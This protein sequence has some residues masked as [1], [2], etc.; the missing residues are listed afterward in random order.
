M[1][2]RVSVGAVVAVFFLACSGS[3]SSPGELKLV[4]TVPGAYNILA[5]AGH[6]DVVAALDYGTLRN[7]SEA[8]LLLGKRDPAHPT[9]LVDLGK[10]PL[11][12]NIS[13]LSDLSVTADWV[14]VACGGVV[15]AVSLTTPA[16]QLVAQFT[17]ASLQA[18]ASGRWLL[19]VDGDGRTV[20]VRDLGAPG[21]GFPQVGS[22]FDAGATVTAVAA[23]PGGFLAFTTA[24]YGYVAMAQNVPAYTFVSSPDVKG[25]TR[26]HLYGTKLYVGGPS[27]FMGKIRV[28]R[29]DVAT[30]SSATLEAFVD[31]D[32]AFV[33][34]AYDPAGS[35]VAFAQV[36]ADMGL[37]RLFLV[38]DTGGALA[39]PDTSYEI[40]GV[41]RGTTSLPLSH[42]K[43]GMLYVP[44]HSNVYVS[45]ASD[46]ALFALP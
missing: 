39:P 5:V 3:G 46:I 31:I 20:H 15:S 18:I 33:D 27:V 16:P 6:D 12:A 2:T 32:G 25:F 45:T 37:H 29:I 30:P 23:V 44:Y 34:F 11:G 28:G 4:R 19:H 38:R 8:L 22:P 42:A 14:T 17:T 36:S 1:A 43:S 40:R 24:G 26:A 13:S 7:A 35:Y 21:A 9:D 10:V 41:V